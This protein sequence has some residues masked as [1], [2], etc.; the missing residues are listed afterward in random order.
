MPDTSPVDHR[1]PG[2]A[3]SA[4]R[5]IRHGHFW[6]G[7]RERIILAELARCLE[8]RP[9]PSVLEIGCGDGAVLARM[10]PG[11]RALGVDDRWEDLLL[12]RRS[13]AGSVAAAQGSALPFLAR[14][15]AVCLFDVL[16]HVRDD[17]GLLDSAVSRVARGGF[18]IATV[19]AGPSLWSAAD[20]YAGHYRRYSAGALR[21]LFERC[22]LRVTALYPFF[23]ALWLPARVN[24]LR[25][26]RREIHDVAREYS[27][28]PVFN[29]I[30]TVVLRLEHAL[31]GRSRLGRGT[32]LIAVGRRS[33]ES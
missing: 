15:D 32:S 7:H 29:R 5:T 24:A 16:E 3:A 27:V 17:A 8:G 4:L 21:A 13:G 30:L 31:F 28:H 14:F 10:P 33:E 20:R 23:R 1:F 18:V 6:F 12:A 26:D 19:P 22:G 25:G 9:S 2:G 11:W